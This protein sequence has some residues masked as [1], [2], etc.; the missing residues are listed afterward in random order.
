MTCDRGAILYEMMI[1]SLNAL[2]VTGKMASAKNGMNRRLEKMGA[3]RLHE[4]RIA[5]TVYTRL[6]A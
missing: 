5:Y 3:I 2:I 6:F 4:R 1:L